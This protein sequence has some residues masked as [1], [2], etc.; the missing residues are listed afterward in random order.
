MVKITK[1]QP[2]LENMLKDTRTELELPY[3][4]TVSEIHC[5]LVD[6]WAY[7][8]RKS[9]G[10]FVILR[11]SEGSSDVAQSS[12][13]ILFDVFPWAISLNVR[14][15]GVMHLTN[16]HPYVCDQQRPVRP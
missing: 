5:H 14:L 9:P 13:F 7:S 4:V 16:P 2:E 12:L 15:A 10:Q 6:A 8:D 1:G 3:M 11:M